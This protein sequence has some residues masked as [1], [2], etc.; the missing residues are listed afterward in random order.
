MSINFVVFEETPPS[1]AVVRST[2]PV[3]DQDAPAAK[4]ETPTEAGRFDT[5]DNDQLGL[6]TRSVGGVFHGSEK[7]SDPVLLDVAS[8]DYQNRVNAQVASSG[9]A[10]ARERAGEWGHGSLQWQDS[11]ERR[12]GQSFGG[13]YFAADR[14]GANSPSTGVNGVGSVGVSDVE[15]RAEVNASASSVVSDAA[16]W[17]TMLGG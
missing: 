17:S 3:V 12:S 14:R 10:A 5:D 16:W 2:S 6:V 9:T 8:A 1:Q 7:G 11:M 4:I 13:D 15:S